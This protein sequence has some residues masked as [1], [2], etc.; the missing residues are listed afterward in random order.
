MQLQYFQ[1]NFYKSHIFLFMLHIV[2]TV[3]Q[4][5]VSSTAQSNSQLISQSSA[6]FS[7]TFEHIERVRLNVTSH[8]VITDS[9][10][11]MCAVTC[12]LTSWCASANL[13][14]DRS[15]CQLLSEDVS[16]TTSLELDDGWS[17]IR[18]Y[19]LFDMQ[20]CILFYHDVTKT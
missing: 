19:K 9:S 18:K 6:Q 17:Y 5:L 10:P 11:V 7:R 14:P 12:Q 4:L 15:I 16:D 1:C 3:L 8:D 20:I 13:A 2:S